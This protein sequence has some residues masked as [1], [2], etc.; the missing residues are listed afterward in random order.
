MHNGAFFFLKDKFYA[1]LEANLRANKTNVTAG[2]EHWGVALHEVGF[3][4]L[5][6]CSE[7]VEVATKFLSL[8]FGGAV[9]FFRL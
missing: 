9:A 6:P 5:F 3:K 8:V 1:S 7:V 2:K 4:G